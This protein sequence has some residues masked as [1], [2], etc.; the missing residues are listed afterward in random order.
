MREERKWYYLGLRHLR[1]S[2]RSLRS[3]F[4]DGAVFHAY[5][6]FECLLSA[7]I[8]AKGYPVPP[9]G[10]TSLRLPSGKT[11]QAYPSPL[12]MIQDHNA[13][14]ARLVFFDQ[15]ADRTE[16]YYRDY[17]RLRTFLVYQDRLDSL[18]YDATLNRLPEDQYSAS[19]A[20]ELLR[21]LNQFARGARIKIA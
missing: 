21:M 1:M 12:G 8:A 4:A 9:E 5:H 13:H 20:D 15:L 7:V 2:H 17:R 6:G 14:K 19:F 16:L 3:G 11:V 10:W 18:Y